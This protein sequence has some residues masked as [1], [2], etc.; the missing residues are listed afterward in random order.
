VLNP[1]QGTALVFAVSGGLQASWLS[2]LPAFQDHL[3]ATVSDLGVALALL[4][5]GAVIGMI[6]AGQIYRH[7]GTRSLVQLASAGG[8]LMLVVVAVVPAPGQFSAA[9]FVFGLMTGAWD[10]AMN[11]HAS[12]VERRFNRHLMMRFHGFWSAGSVFG[13]GVGVVAARSDYPIVSQC[14]L[15]GFAAVAL[16]QLGAR[17]FLPEEPEERARKEPAAP[18]AP[19][20][21]TARFIVL[22]AIILLGA[23]IEG[24]AGDWLAV[25]LA[26]A[27]K[28]PHS[29]AADGY[30]VFVVAMAAG[31]LGAD[32][33]YGWIRRR[34]PAK[35]LWRY[36]R[37]RDSAVRIGVAVSIIGVWLTVYAPAG[38]PV[39]LGA[40][41]WGVGICILFP[42]VL[43]AAGSEP[44]SGRAVALLSSIGYCA[45][46]IGPLALGVAPSALG[47]N[48]SNLKLGLT[49]VLPVFAAAIAGLAHWIYRS[50]PVA[51][52]ESAPR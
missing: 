38:L 32:Q 9:M 44:G 19:A 41:F 1:V 31:R 30:A 11:I 36:V 17:S 4:G 16:G 6:V 47:E 7:A 13:A 42:A 45:S 50:T 24:A 26:D 5:A 48:A 3:G 49:W 28:L 8:S 43:S 27:R 40:A 10:A 22:G 23:L 52:P 39:Y 21:P 2:R 18:S 12:A 34:D 46:M 35:Q 29:A 20:R 25:L 15:V 14:V 51:V 37:R 33:V